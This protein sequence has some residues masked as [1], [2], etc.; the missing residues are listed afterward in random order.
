MSAPEQRESPGV[1]APPPLIYGAFLALGLVLE[2]LWALAALPSA[3][4]FG[5]GGP[6]VLAG[7]ALAAWAALQFRKLGTHLDVRKPTTA[8]ATAGPYRV[9]RNPIYLALTLFYL[10]LGL[11]AGSLWVLVLAGPAL[12]VMQL[13]VVRREERYLE[14]KFGAAYLDYARRVRRWI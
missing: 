11:A 13:G 8:L 3:L 1:V 10:G 12:A 4:R 2:Q 14:R 6:L 5:L 7:L 9:S